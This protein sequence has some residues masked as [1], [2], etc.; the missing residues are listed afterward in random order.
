M[1]AAVITASVS[2]V[3][4][5]LVFLLNQR[6][7]L[8]QER[9]QARLTRINAQLREL[10]GPLHALVD[11]NERVWAELGRTQLPP[12]DERLSVRTLPPQAADNWRRWFRSTLMPTNLRM[13]ELIIK[14]ADLLIEPEFP[15]PLQD[16]CAH[17]TSYE[18]LLGAD[19]SGER[20][21]IGHPG[22]PYVEYVR[23][24][25]ARLKAEQLRLLRGKRWTNGP[26]GSA[27]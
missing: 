4:A 6:S 23:T 17:V 7:Q 9:R 27:G 21:L 1:E 3:V 5:V 15:K 24:S 18:V 11:V 22:E 12:P 8:L 10:Y 2:V 16:F 25:F 14:H 19:E 20:P 13:R 26:R